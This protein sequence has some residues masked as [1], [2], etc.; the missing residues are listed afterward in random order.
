MVTSIVPD[1]V[2]IDRIIEILKANKLLQS[3]I[4]EWRFGDL[5]DEATT[6]GEYSMSASREQNASSYP[7]CYVT[8]ATNPEVSRT[9]IGSEG[10]PDI[11]VPQIREYELW[12]VFVTTG[13]TPAEAQ[14]SLYKITAMAQAVLE[15]NLRLKT[16]AGADP[17]C[18]TCTVHPQRRV[19]KFRGTLLEAMTLRVRPSGVVAYGGEKP[20]IA[21]N[22]Y[23]G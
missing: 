10:N 6:R 12:A 14:K 2:F 1:H 19:E 21:E 23:P 8:T 17:L 15:Q 20:P 5:G 13:A 9:V 18:M 4:S 11:M 16:P 22:T 7:L 3:M